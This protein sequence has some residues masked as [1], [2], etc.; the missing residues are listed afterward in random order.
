MTIRQQLFV[1]SFFAIVVTSL[2]LMISYKY[3]WFDGQTTILL[4]I[5]SM[6]SSVITMILATLFSN[7]TI[8]KINLLSKKTEKIAAG[9]YQLDVLHIKSP[10]E[11]KS[12]NESFNRMAIEIKRQMEQ[13]HQEEQEK[14]MM[15]ENF[16]HDL[17]TPLSSIKSYSE[18]LKDGIIKS[19]DEKDK[20][21]QILMMQSDRLSLMFDELNQVISLHNNEQNQ[22]V[23]KIDE[24]LLGLLDNFTPVM[25]RENRAFIVDADKVAEFRQVEIAIERILSNFINNAIKFSDSDIKVS[26]KDDGDHVKVSIEDSGIGIAQK[27]INRI[28]DRTY[29]VEQSRNKMT[30]GSGLGLYIAKTLANQIDSEIEV[31]S[32]LNVGSVFS[33]IITKK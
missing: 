24:L 6:L 12:L 15:I 19:D 7:P 29:R 16:A 18:G 10:K 31:K 14:V 2:L 33:L 3:M 28:F 25:K 1:A 5:C 9:D 23:F 22:T 11:L 27:D 32:K 20:A 8:K 21:Y 4:T 30:G 26:V 17:K 13:I